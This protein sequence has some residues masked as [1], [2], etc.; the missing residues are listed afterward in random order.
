M[1]QAVCY[2]NCDV[3]NNN[4]W[5]H[6]AFAFDNT[7]SAL[8][9]YRNGALIQNRTRPGTSFGRFVFVVCLPLL[10]LLCFIAG[11]CLLMAC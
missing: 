3:V 5:T 7:N 1:L 6:F 2:T 8:A 10:N 4:I 9:I 11:R